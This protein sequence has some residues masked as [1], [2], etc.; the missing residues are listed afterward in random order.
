M[1]LPTVFPMSLL[2]IKTE[3]GGPG[4]L[5]SYLAGGGFVQSGT[6]N[7][8]SVAIP[9]AA[10][11]SFSEMLGSS[12][13]TLPGNFANNRIAGAFSFGSVGYGGSSNLFVAVNV[14]GA[15]YS[16][17]TGVTWTQRSSVSVNPS[18]QAIPVLNSNFVLSCQAGKYFHSTDGITWT[19][20][21]ITVGSGGTNS[22]NYGLAAGAFGN[23]LYVIA[24]GNLTTNGAPQIFTASSLTSNVGWTAH[25]ISGWTGTNHALGGNMAYNGSVYCTLGK[26]ASNNHIIAVTSPDA[27]TWTAHDVTT[28]IATNGNL[29]VVSDGTN[30]YCSDSGSANA[31]Y[32]SPDGFTWTKHTNASFIGGND[33]LF[34]GNNGV[35]LN[36]TFDANVAYATGNPATAT[37]T[38]KIVANTGTLNSATEGN[39]IYVVVGSDSSV[40][41]SA[42]HSP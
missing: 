16:S 40:S 6:S 30:F 14:L 27:T 38:K 35:F 19:L 24:G 39:N 29:N 17:P 20:H 4:N 25:A 41:G 3:F 21:Q 33:G 34:V 1:T 18:A 15:I 23:S 9:S 37:W 26:D 10:P 22:L 7:G 8:T 11:I 5:L 13:V 36:M 32:S 31:V 12:A 2:Q 42:F 28:V